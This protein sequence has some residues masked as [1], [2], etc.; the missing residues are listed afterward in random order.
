[1]SIPQSEV[2]KLKRDLKDRDDSAD[3]RAHERSVAIVPA[4]TIGGRAMLRLAVV[5]M[6]AI[7]LSGCR[8]R[9]SGTD[10]REYRP[11]PSELREICPF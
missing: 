6:L 2:R 9:M 8:M 3:E 4:E 10:G 7:S 1:M 5:V 11:A